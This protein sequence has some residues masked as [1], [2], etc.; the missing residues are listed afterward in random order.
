[1]SEGRGVSRRQ[2]LRGAAAAAVAPY[3]IC[4]TAQGRAPA[5]DRITLGMIGLGNMGGGHLDTLVH[6]KEIQI[7]AVCDVFRPKREAA[8]KKVNETYA[9]ERG[10]AEYRGCDAYNEFE[11]VLERPDI[12]AVLIAT[13]DHWH[14]TIAIAAC[15]AGKDVY[16][17]KPLTLTIAEALELGRTVRRYDRVFQ[18]GS[19]QRSDA[20]FRLACELVRSGRIGKV[21]KVNVGVGGP[22]GE[23]YYPEEPVPDGLDWDRWLGPTPW[24]PY[25][26][27]RCSGS[28]SGGFRLI[29]E[30]SGGMMTDWGA[31]HFDIAQWGLGMDGSGPVEVIPPPPDSPVHK[32]I[33]QAKWESA[34]D[35]SQALCFK[36]QNGLPVYHGNANGILFTGTDG[37]IEVNRGYLKSWPDSIIKEPLGPRDVHLYESPGHHQDWINC[38]RSRKRPICDVAVGV[39]SITMCHLGNIAWWLGRPLRYDPV[40]PK[41]IGDAEAAR[42]LERPKREAWRL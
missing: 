39:S 42:W 15:R 23:K 6:H 16:C 21:V 13:P 12:D 27:E 19:Q 36:Y 11:R 28:Y 29:R 31:H 24:Y 26:A 10:D 7:L 1:M 35:D 25:N 8:Q 32:C 41:I 3:V 40:K 17:E 20:N 33:G 4:R 5:S 14:A 2:F 38:I 34:P 18:T 22:S 30:Y 37:K 9:A